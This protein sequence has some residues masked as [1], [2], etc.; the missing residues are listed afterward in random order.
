MLGKKF[1]ILARRYNAVTLN[2][3]LFARYQ[4]RLLVWLASLSLL[5]AFV[6]AMTVQFIGGARLLETA[7]GIPY[8]TGLLIFGVSIALY[9]AYG[10]FRASVLN[11]TMQGMVMLI[12]TIVLLVGVIHAAGG[13]GHAVETLQS[14]DVKLVS[15]QGAEDILSPTFMASFG[16]WSAS[17]LLVC[18][19]PQ[20]AVSPTKTAKPCIAA[21]LSAP[22]W[23]RS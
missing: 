9:T 17:A 8:D 16:C 6:G 12:G 18:H 2:D 19:I 22:S 13:V 15:P 5:V 10:G 11:D 14:I 7:A 21:S 3:M 23:W 4:S 20:C 1:A